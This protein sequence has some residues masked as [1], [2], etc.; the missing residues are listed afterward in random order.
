MLTWLLG[1]VKEPVALGKL[2]PMLETKPGALE[3]LAGQKAG[4]FYLVR[5]G[6]VQPVRAA[7]NLI[8]TEQLPEDRI[9]DLARATPA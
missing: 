4:E 8:P 2:K 5:E 9:L 3:K 7:R 1:R 6:D